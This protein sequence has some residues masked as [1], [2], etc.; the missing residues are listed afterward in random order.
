MKGQPGVES[1]RSE[2]SQASKGEGLQGFIDMREITALASGPAADIFD[3]FRHCSLVWNYFLTQA[4]RS[5]W[6]VLICSWWSHWCPGRIKRK[7]WELFPFPSY[8]M[9]LCPFSLP[10]SS[11]ILIPFEPDLLSLFSWSLCSYLLMPLTTSVLEWPQEKSR[12]THGWRTKVARVCTQPSD[13]ACLLGPDTLTGTQT[14]AQ[15][16]Q[17]ERQ[18]DPYCFICIVLLVSLP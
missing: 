9:P 7:Q 14:Q 6:G 4:K 17:H 1:S 15:K 13:P 12:A 16:A 8:L 18:K 10:L 3:R 11:S 2:E 5:E